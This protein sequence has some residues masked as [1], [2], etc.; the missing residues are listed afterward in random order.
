LV[1]LKAEEVGVKKVIHNSL[2]DC[3]LFVLKGEG[4]EEYLLFLYKGKV[5]YFKVM[6]PFPGRWDCYDALYSPWGLYGFVF[7]ETQLSAKVKEKL[8]ELRR[9]VKGL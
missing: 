4:E 3:D 1:E 9:V 2:D 7:N 6:P 8:E 5:T